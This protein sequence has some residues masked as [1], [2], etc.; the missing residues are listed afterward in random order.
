M[1][2]VSNIGVNLIPSTL[3]KGS[4]LTPDIGKGPS[5][6]D[7]LSDSMN[8]KGL[9]QTESKIRTLSFSSHAVDRMSQRGMY[10]TAEQMTEIEGA[11]N[12]AADKGSKGTLVIANDTALIV[13]VDKRKVVTVMDKD[14]LKE[15]VFTNIDSTVII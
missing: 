13:D 5:F 3:D 15:N 11:V 1:S 9:A 4:G 14:N 8:P 6:K 2:E 10:F 12:K 7:T